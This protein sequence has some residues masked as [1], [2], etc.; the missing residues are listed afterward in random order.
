MTMA[1]EGNRFKEVGIDTPKPLIEYNGKPLFVN[2]MSTL[3]NI[4]YDSVTFVVRH[5]HIEK[6]H[7]DDEIKKYY[8]NAII[9]AIADTTRGAAETAFI[10][11][12]TLILNEVADFTDR[13]LVMDCDVIVHSERWASI[14]Q[15]PH[16]DGVLLSFKSDS[17]KY[18]Y[19]KVDDSSVVIETAEKNPISDHALTS[20]Y[21]IKKIEYFVDAFHE[22]EMYK[23]VDG[24]PTYKEM[25]MSILYNFMIADGK[26]I[27]LVDADKIISLGTPE[28]L[29]KAKEEIK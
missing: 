2:S 21:F 18:S 12:R 25:Y 26:K 1:G 27:I 11:V 14:I 10:A 28:E 17:D 23:P 13:M 24:E 6:Y 9:I 8:P 19:A 4:K 16:S 15:K 20:P 22:M 3:D 5:E 7:I 29:E